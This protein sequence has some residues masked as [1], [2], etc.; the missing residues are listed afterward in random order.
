MAR[1]AAL[2]SRHLQIWSAT[3]A[4]LPCAVRMPWQGRK[5]LRVDRFDGR[6]LLDS[7]P[8]APAAGT[9]TSGKAP[10]P[11]AER[12]QFERYRDLVEKARLGGL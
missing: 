7:I 6:L 3:F 4:T 11:Q 12:Y 8:M 9:T 5:D 10:D 1:R 2:T